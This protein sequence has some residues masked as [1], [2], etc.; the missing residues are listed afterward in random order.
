MNNGLQVVV[1]PDH[2]APVVTHMIWYKVGAADEPEGES[3][4]AHF[5][6]HLMFK[7][8]KTHPGGAFSAMVSELG[9]QENAFTSQD[10]TSYYQRVAKEHLPTVMEFEADRMTG[11]VLSDEVVNPERDVVL[12]ERRMRTDNDPGSRLSEAIA[13]TLF[14]NHPY[15]TPIIGWQHEIEQLDRANALSFYDRFYT[16]NNAIVVV[17][18]DVT[19][20]E[21]R[22][23]AEATYGKIERRGDVGPRMRPAEPDLL[24]ARRV[25][26]ADPRARQPSLTR[27]Y[28]VPSYANAEGRQA[29]ALDLLAFILGGGSTSRLHRSLVADQS[30]AAS[31][32]SYY[33]GDALD[34]SRFVVYAIPRENIDMERLEKALDAE[35]SKIVKDGVTAEELTRAKKRL[36]AETIYAQDSQ[37]TL[38][39][40]YGTTLTTG[41]T[42]EDV[43]EW[44][45]VIEAVSAEEIQAAAKLAL[46]INRSVTGL[47]LTEEAPPQ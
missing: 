35:L 1:I 29:H 3:G 40:A 46:Q 9:G 47:L 10:Y 23:L 39:R 5:L 7:G 17:A 25:T 43:K 32:G 12:E 37:T 30:I 13:A 41:G 2:R 6:E 4:I 18:G 42:V 34:Q 33:Q 38:A 11:L 14:V 36:V 21:V 19:T 31:A 20:G 22:T 28:I 15:G 8:T 44:P 24:A 27:T 26:L 45:S 16:P